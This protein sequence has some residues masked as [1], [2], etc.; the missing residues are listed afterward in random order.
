MTEKS[1]RKMFF[2]GGYSLESIQAIK[3]P[4]NLKPLGI[5]NAILCIYVR[6]GCILKWVIGQFSDCATHIDFINGLNLCN[7]VKPQYYE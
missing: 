1:V 4:C 6:L 5:L 7:S 3:V 2:F